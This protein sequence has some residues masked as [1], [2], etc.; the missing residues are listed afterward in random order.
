[1]SLIPIF[2]LVFSQLAVGGFALLLL[3]PNGLVGRGFYRL[4]GAIYLFAMILARCANLAISGQAVTLQTFFLAWTGQE[5]VF[6]LVLFLVLFAYTVSLWMRFELANRGLLFAGTIVGA[7]WIAYSARFYLTE[8]NLPAEGILL[9]LQ[10]LISAILLGVVNSGMWFGHWYLVTPNL[11]VS[12][13]KKFN[14]IFLIS[15]LL[16]ISLFSL[17]FVLR[18]GTFE[19]VQLDFFHQLILGMRVLIGFGG[20]FVLYLIVWYCL[21]DNAVVQD[22]VGATR[23][24]TGFLYI[25]MIAVFMGECC[26]RFLLLEV[27]FI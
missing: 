14:R 4:M 16:S 18:G 3:V 19:T 15:I 26:A 17:N 23:A 20:S 11:P 24:A 12:H 27:G 1:M 9:P 7:I 13:L 21:R 10:F 8:I 22:A 6:T 2:Y 25:A 5:V